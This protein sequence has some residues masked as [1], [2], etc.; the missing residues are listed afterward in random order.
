MKIITALIGLLLV[1]G[2]ATGIQRQVDTYPASIETEGPSMER[3]IAMHSEPQATAKPD[4]SATLDTSELQYCLVLEQDVLD[5]FAKLNRKDGIISAE[6][7]KLERITLRMQQ[8]ETR[9]KTDDQLA[10]S[11]STLGQN[12]ATQ[13]ASVLSLFRDRSAIYT[14]L[15]FLIND[16]EAVCAGKVF[17]PAALIA[18]CRDE[19]AGESFRCKMRF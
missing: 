2:C 3:E 16:T 15:N 12:R 14:R 8:I 13:I 6:Y 1:T 18:A 17:R 7:S 9:A 10:A 5:V 11:Y 4:N 19:V